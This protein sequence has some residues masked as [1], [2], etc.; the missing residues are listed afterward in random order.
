MDK[1]RKRY[2][3]ENVKRF[4]EIKEN[5]RR[6]SLPVSKSTLL[7]PASLPPF[8][9]KKYVTK[10]KTERKKAHKSGG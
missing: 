7:L 1:K 2:K 8:S 9:K 5:V 10:L 4:V 3:T 6:D